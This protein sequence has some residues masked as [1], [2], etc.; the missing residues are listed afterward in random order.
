MTYNNAV[1]IVE[2]VFRLASAGFPLYSVSDTGTL[3]YVPQTVGAAALPQVISC[4]WIATEE[5][6][7][8]A[9]RQI[10]MEL[11]EYP[12]MEHVWL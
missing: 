12:P 7:L 8:L 10:T 5:R 1:P 4:G 6:Y 2:G 3:V 9:L 11:P